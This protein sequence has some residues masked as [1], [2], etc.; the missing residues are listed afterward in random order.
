MF[1]LTAAV[2]IDIFE[3]LAWIFVIM[4]VGAGIVGLW[5]RMTGSRQT[6]DWQTGHREKKVA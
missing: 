2:N 3:V 5:Q 6:D 1:D 4:G